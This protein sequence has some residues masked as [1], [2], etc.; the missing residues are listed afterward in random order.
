MTKELEPHVN[1]KVKETLPLV[2][3]TA[4]LNDEVGRKIL[5]KMAQRGELDEVLKRVAM[6]M[7][8]G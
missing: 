6:R 8:G 1:A 7:Q 5:T 3:Q 2:L 4:L